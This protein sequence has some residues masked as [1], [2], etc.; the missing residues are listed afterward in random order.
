MSDEYTPTVDEVRDAWID[1][2]I[3]YG[4]DR[5][6]IHD[7]EERL[8]AAFDRFMAA[9]DAEV[10]A[11]ALRE[12]ADDIKL[13]DW[14]H[15]GNVDDVSNAEAEASTWLMARAAALLPVPVSNTKEEK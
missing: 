1:A 6:N 4:F 10:K 8:H 3:G 15:H 5:E 12:A 2:R 11:E 9:H 13:G 7:R 14:S